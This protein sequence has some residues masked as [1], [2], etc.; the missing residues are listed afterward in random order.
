[1]L[2]ALQWQPNWEPGIAVIWE[3]CR[4]EAGSAQGPGFLA[5]WWMRLSHS[6]LVPVPAGQGSSCSTWSWSPAGPDGQGE[7]KGTGPVIP[8][9]PGAQQGLQGSGLRGGSCYPHE[10]W[11]RL[12]AAVRR[13]LVVGI[14][15][16]VDP[17]AQLRGRYS[18]VV[19]V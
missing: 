5:G 1:M 3:A 9:L 13:G 7:S 4:A 15:M 18:S 12:R 11:E 14:P 17:V 19:W 8:R 2:G 6:R 16:V 10:L